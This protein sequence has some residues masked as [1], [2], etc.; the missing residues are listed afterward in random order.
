MLP[1]LQL[2]GDGRDHSIR[3][4]VE[5]LAQQ[6][7]LTDDDRRELLPSGR[8]P[9][10]YNRVGWARTYLKKAGLL[11]TPRRGHFAITNRGLDVLAQS[12]QRIDLGL[13][14][15]FLEFVEFISAKSGGSTERDDGEGGSRTPEER[16][17][18]AYDELR[19]GLAVELLEAI[20]SSSPGFFEQVVVDLLLGMGYGGTRRDAGQAIGRIGDEGI[21]GIIKEDRLGLDTV[22]VQ[23]KRWA[24]AVGRPE[25][26]RFVGALEGHHARKGVF[27]TTSSFTPAAIEYASRVD[28]RVV[29]IDGDMLGQLMID[30]GIGVNTIASYDL[31]HLDT[32]YFSEE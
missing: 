3:E 16:I 11:T 10:F 5:T 29:L 26:Q 13:L 28:R 14:R 8:Q 4:A 22:Y 17:E 19:R 30:H 32:D 15:Q 24:T 25:I 18:A 12:P 21:D 9:L 6:F 20:A 1:L 27:I 23:A 2:A 31:K 7:E